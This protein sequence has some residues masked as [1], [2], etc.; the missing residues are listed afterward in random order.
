MKSFAIAALAVVASARITDEEDFAFMRYLANHSKSYSTLEE[1]NLRFACF[2]RVNQELEELNAPGSSSFHDHNFL[3]D[4]T[5]EEKTRILGLRKLSPKE[6]A[7]TF[8]ASSVVGIPASVN[9][10]TAGNYVN[11]IQDQGN[12]G[13]CWAFSAVAAMESAH[14]IFHG[15]LLKLSEQNLVSCSTLQ[16]NLGC[17]GGDYPYAWNYTRNHPLESEVNYPYTSGTTGKTGTCTYDSTKGI[18]SATSYTNVGTTTTEIKTAIAQQPQSVGIEADTTYFQ[19][20]SSGVLTSAAKCGTTMDHAVV[21]VGYG[22]D[23]TYGGYYIV[24]NSWGTSWG[25]N[26]YVNIGQ[27]VAPGICGINQ[28]VDFPTVN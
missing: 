5:A 6:T 16:G 24:R 28:D 21:A 23:P 4:W 3:S 11:P 12:C 7:T 9:W 13:S 26:G 2:R 18:M 19:S 22:T 25:M 20:Y 27:A 1:F 8:D 14:A 10:V 15:A 17:N